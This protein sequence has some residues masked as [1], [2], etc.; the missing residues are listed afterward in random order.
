ML[1]EMDGMPL[2][3]GQ[4]IGTGET[5]FISDPQLQQMVMKAILNGPRPFALLKHQYWLNF[6]QI[7]HDKP[8]KQPIYMY[9]KLHEYPS[10]PLLSATLFSS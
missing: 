1:T 4:Q 3:P 8:I 5:T 2:N 10:P 9:S 6:S 7:D